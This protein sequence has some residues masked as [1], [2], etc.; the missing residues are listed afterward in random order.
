MW[1]WLSGVRDHRAKRQRLPLKSLSTS[2]WCEEWLHTHADVLKFNNS[3][4]VCCSGFKLPLP[5][6]FAPPFLCRFRNTGGKTHAEFGTVLLSDAAEPDRWS[7]TLELCPDTHIS[8]S[9]SGAFKLYCMHL[10][11]IHLWDWCLF[12]FLSFAFAAHL[13]RRLEDLSTSPNNSTVAGGLTRVN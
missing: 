6:F 11:I 9:A 5:F 13:R 3:E 7:E 4:P 1:L 10:K 12:C 8:R 2:Q